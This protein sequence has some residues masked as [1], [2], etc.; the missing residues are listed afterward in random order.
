MTVFNVDFPSETTNIKFRTLQWICTEVL[1]ALAALLNFLPRKSP[2]TTPNQL[3][4]TA[5]SN[6]A[7]PPIPLRLLLL[8]LYRPPRLP[9]K[10]NLAPHRHSPNLGLPHRPRSIHDNLQRH[11][12]ALGLELVLV[13]SGYRRCVDWV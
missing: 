5:S 6:N 8:L 3:S 12:R 2:F 10:H 13:V 9:F 4:H 7:S 11:R 1:L